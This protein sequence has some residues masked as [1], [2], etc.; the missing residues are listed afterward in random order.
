MPRDMK[1]SKDQ[2]VYNC[3]SLAGGVADEDNGICWSLQAMR[4]DSNWPWV[5]QSDIG[6]E[7]KNKD[8]IY[9][10]TDKL[11]FYRQIVRLIAISTSLN[12]N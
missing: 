12:T 10:I 3:N 7:L 11:D 6:A 1:L 4:S 9:K 2:W 8:N 5:D